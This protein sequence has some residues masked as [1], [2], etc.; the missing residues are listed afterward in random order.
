[1]PISVNTNSP[2]MKALTEL[3]K[4]NRDLMTIQ[5]RM[6]S[7]LKITSAKDNGAVFGMAQ[8]LRADISNLAVV[9]DSLDHAI[10][11]TDVAYSASEALSDLMLDMKEKA[12]A[13]SDQSLDDRS[14]SILNEDF[15]VLRNQISIVVGNAE[16]N[17]INL[18]NGTTNELA[19]ITDGHG[20]QAVTIPGYDVRS[21]GADNPITSTTVIDPIA[22]AREALAKIEESLEAQ[23]SRMNSL[24]GRLRTMDT[25]R[26]LAVKTSDILTNN[27]GSMVDA[28]LGKESARLQAAQT[29]QQLQA[30]AL[31]IANQLPTFATQLLN[32]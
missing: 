19:P 15:I 6:N 7:G 2:A 3:N 21:G 31:S 29:K 28:D 5:S 11:V 10:A 20:G 4:S 30:Q 25:I 26:T 9:T 16:F 14:R 32:N 23:A 18:L 8:T 22:S 24:G 27:L 12:L 1:M 17:G 13:A